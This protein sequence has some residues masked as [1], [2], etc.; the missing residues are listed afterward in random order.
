MSKPGKL[1]KSKRLKIPPRFRTGFCR[2]YGPDGLPSAYSPERKR[3]AQIGLDAL[4]RD[5][6]PR[7]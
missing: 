4:L 6:E 5:Q 1:P 7:K 2:V 3:L